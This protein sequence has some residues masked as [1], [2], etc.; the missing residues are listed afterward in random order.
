MA[1]SEDNNPTDF[2]HAMKLAV[3]AMAQHELDHPDESAA[4]LAEAS[5]LI[6]RLR[7]NSAN[8]VHP[9]LLITEGLFREANAKIGGSDE[10]PK[11]NADK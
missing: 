3:L 2:S 8:K 7:E 9:G 10:P 1:N 11:A 5:Q 4:A 6:T